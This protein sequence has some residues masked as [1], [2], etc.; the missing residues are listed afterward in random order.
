[1]PDVAIYCRVSTE[2]Q[3][4][5]GYSL[6]DQIASCK[7]FLLNKGI[8]N[9]IEYIDDGISGKFLDRPA[10]TALR[11]DIA[12]GRIDSVVVYD[13]DRLARKLSIQLLVAEEMEKSKVALHFITGDYDASPEG[14][15]FFS[16]RGA[17]AEFEKA[18]IL[19]RT[20][21]GKRRK[22]MQGKIM[23]DF[24]LYGYNYD[25]E[26]CSYIIN[27]KQAT[28]IRDIFR[29]VSDK[30]LSIEGVQKELKTKIIPSPTGKAVWPTSTI[31]NILRNETYTGTFMSMKY[32][33][34]RSGIKSRTIEKRPKE[35]WIPI[36]VPEIIDE[37]T[38]ERAQKQ[39]KRNA[40]S[41]HKP[42]SAPFLLRGILFCGVCGRRMLAHH[43]RFRDGSYKT[44]YQ[45]SAH[46]YADLR[47]TGVKCPSKSLPSD[48]I[49]KDVWGK[50]VD[51]FKSPEKIK[52]Y[53]PKKLAQPDYS[54]EII[55]LNNLETELIKRRETIVKWF[56]QQM[57]SEKESDE[58]LAKIRSQLVDIQERK[59]ILRP[60]EK[61]TPEISFEEMAKAILPLIQQ[62]DLTPDEMRNIIQ[63]VL[64]KV[65]ATRLDQQKG[66]VSHPKFK[67]TW[68]MI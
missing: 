53:A 36:K 59:N 1:M 28:L 2:D 26:K 9:I 22:A 49:D 5:T 47:N 38:F 18:K 46:R 7:A 29:L 24:K 39:L 27:E 11:D 44:Y 3:A 52:K 30:Q 62:G 61:A 42:V 16:M 45:C 8:T 15:L 35:E 23:Q 12:A 65:T 67:I 50:L 54:E 14:R 48:A 19:D 33:Q 66:S 32:R 10:L 25:A 40:V 34:Q 31:H 4:K 57:I 17:I 21:R 55:R 6:D 68:E 56:G 43:C 41:K 51:A 63:S 13:P 64:A 37:V 20:L 60:E 58:E